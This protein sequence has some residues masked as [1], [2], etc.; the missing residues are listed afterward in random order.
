MFFKFHEWRHLPS[1]TCLAPRARVVVQ[2]DEQRIDE[3]IPD[4]EARGRL[5]EWIT[6]QRQTQ[7]AVAKKAKV[8]ST[9]M[10]DPIDTSKL[11]L[12]Q[13]WDIMRCMDEK[14]AFHIWHTNRCQMFGF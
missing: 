10:L 2:L 9:S 7:R 3:F 14:A 12:L 8:P 6:F 1:N 11:F 5:E 13:L 4:A